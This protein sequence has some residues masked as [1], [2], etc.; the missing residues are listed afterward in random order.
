[1]LPFK[2]I[3]FPVDYSDRCRSIIPYVNDMVEHFSA[4]LTVVHARGVG[5]ARYAELDVADPNWEEEVRQ[6]EEQ[7]LRKFVSETFPGRHVDSILEIGEPGHVID[8]VIQHH[9]T[10]LVMMPT[11]GRGPVRRLLLGSITAKVLHDASAA[12]WTCTERMAGHAESVPYKS[13]LCAVDLSDETEAVVRAAVSLAESYH[14]RLSLVHVVEMPPPNVDVDFTLFQNDIVEAA[15]DGLRGLKQKLGI[16]V[17]H[18]AIVGLTADAVRQT[19]LDKEADL[20]V[21]GRG[22]SQGTLT[23]AWSQLYAMVRESPCPVLSI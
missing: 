6:L 8:Q 19:A 22:R 21:A 16:D 5:A 9:G 7:R 14:A 1:M 23:R 18:V 17:P 13:I 20:I 11:H 2:R 10:D 15:N 12:V 4:A 3:L